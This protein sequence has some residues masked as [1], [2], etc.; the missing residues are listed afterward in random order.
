MEKKGVVRAFKKILYPGV[1]PF[2]SKEVSK[3]HA[4]ENAFAGSMV[5]RNILKT[6]NYIKALE[7]ELQG[8]SISV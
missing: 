8:R 2:H 5:R 6:E 1:L 3:D 4:Y 7:A